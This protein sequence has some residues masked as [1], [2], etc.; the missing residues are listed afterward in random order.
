MGELDNR[1]HSRGERK[2]LNSKEQGRMVTTYC[3][4]QLEQTIG[5]GEGV[6][7][8]SEGLPCGPLCL[9]HSGIPISPGSSSGF[10]ESSVSLRV[11][12]L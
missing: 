1:G 9:A 4:K 12:F 11:S 5:R 2:Q 7:L 10:Y 3:R 6:Y 8:S